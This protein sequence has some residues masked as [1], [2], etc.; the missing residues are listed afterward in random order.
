MLIGANE[1]LQL[2]ICSFDFAISIYIVD[3]N[4]LKAALFTTQQISFIFLNL[5]VNA[6]HFSI[7]VHNSI[8]NNN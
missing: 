2:S 1:I 4:E 8:T 6:V 5:D 3:R 7:I